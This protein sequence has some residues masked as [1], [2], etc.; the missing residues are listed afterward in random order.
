MNQMLRDDPE[1][2]KFYE[3][4]TMLKR[5]SDPAE[6]ASTVVFFLSDFASCKSCEERS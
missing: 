5:I 3:D 1:R 2:K 4:Q 6:Q